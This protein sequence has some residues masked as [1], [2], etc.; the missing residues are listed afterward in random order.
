MDEF[1]TNFTSLLQYVPYIQE[2][3]V[4]VKCFVSSLPIFMRERPEFDNLRMM[5]EAIRKVRIF[6]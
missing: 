6:H 2:D 1:V 3:I 5:D 4:E